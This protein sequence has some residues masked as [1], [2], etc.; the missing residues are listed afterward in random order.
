MKISSSMQHILLICALLSIIAFIV[1]LS[2]NNME[3]QKNLA[4]LKAKNEQREEKEED[5]EIVRSISRQLEEIAFQQKDL[6][7]IRLREAE[8]QAQIAEKMRLQAESQQKI[9]EE[10]RKI[11][12]EERQNAEQQR[13]IAVNERE[14]A[15]RARTEAEQLRQRA[16]GKSLG[17]LSVNQYNVGNKELAMILAYASWY[18][19]TENDGDLF[20]TEVFEALNLLGGGTDNYVEHKAAVSTIR[21]FVADDQYGK[22]RMSVFTCGRYGEIMMDVINCSNNTVINKMLLFSNKDYDF[23]DMYVDRDGMVYAKSL[24]GTVIKVSSVN[25]EISV[26]KEIPEN[27][28][29]NFKHTNKSVRETRSGKK[30]AIGNNKGEI[31]FTDEATG[32]VKNLLGHNSEITGLFLVG[33]SLFSSSLDGTLRIWDV[34]SAVPDPVTLVKTESWIYDME[35]STD[36][37]TL[38]LGCGDG[39]ITSVLIDPNVLA[40]RIKSKVTRNLTQKEWSEYIGKDVPYIEFVKSNKL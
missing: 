26:L 14:T 21:C 7:D 27:I 37:M 23:R 38:W 36:G 22:D 18:F 35:N 13:Q 2:V 3:L 32:E 1:F 10:E 15:V 19:T 33:E 25:T 11:A 39:S 9:A 6:S 4:E 30:V 40:E 24:D 16:I 31:I 20:D 34:K 28:E 8:Q 5:G 29:K 12:A 17:T